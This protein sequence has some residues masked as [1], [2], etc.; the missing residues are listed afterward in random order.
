[1]DAFPVQGKAGREKDKAAKSTS[2]T[3]AGAK[4]CRM[5]FSFVAVLAGYEATTA[6][7]MT[8]HDDSG[9]A[10]DHPWLVVCPVH[11]IRWF[12]TAKMREP[13]HRIGDDNFA[14]N[15]S[16]T[17]KPLLDQA[18]REIVADSWEKKDVDTFLKEHFDGTW[19]TLSPKV[20]LD[21]I[22]QLKHTPPPNAKE[23]EPQ[24]SPVMAAGPTDEPPA[25]VDRETGAFED[26]PPQGQG[27][28]EGMGESTEG[29]H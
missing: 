5:A 28:M 12:K 11:N 3:W 29:E 22:E 23:P 8:A 20:Q 10:D 14:C 2:Q 4:A 24:P 19:S 16:R 13:A 21:A 17:L 6:E 7:E 9:E 1:M 15:Q 18:L 27:A 26:P 25:G